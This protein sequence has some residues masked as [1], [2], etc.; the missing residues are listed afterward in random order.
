MAIE[1]NNVVMAC[2]FRFLRRPTQAL[3][4]LCAA[5]ALVTVLATSW[6]LAGLELELH[7]PPSASTDAADISVVLW[8]R[9]N[10][11]V[12]QTLQ[13]LSKEGLAASYFNALVLLY[14]S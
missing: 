12:F 7:L 6:S 1:R 5:T 3:R 10:P 11:D 9:R 8:T 2:F 14:H 13:Q 4:A